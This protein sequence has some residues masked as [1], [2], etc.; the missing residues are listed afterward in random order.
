MNNYLDSNT[1]VRMIVRLLWFNRR[2]LIQCTGLTLI[3]GNHLNRSSQPPTSLAHA[4]TPLSP[5][6]TAATMKQPSF[7]SN[8]MSMHVLSY[9]EVHSRKGPREVVFASPQ[10]IP[11]ARYRAR[12]ILR[13]LSF[14]IH[15]FRNPAR[16]RA[17]QP[18]YC[19]W[20][21]SERVQFGIKSNSRQKTKYE[22]K[23]QQFKMCILGFPFWIK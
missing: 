5:R 19:W 4:H 8:F 6:I 22:T 9:I 10:A 1:R 20:T 16:T 21:V 2:H 17:A 3:P 7:H 12:A 18:H 23:E 11:L 15:S 14:Q 13:L